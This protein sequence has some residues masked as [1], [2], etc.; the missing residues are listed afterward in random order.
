MGSNILLNVIQWSSRTV[1]RDRYVCRWAVVLAA[2]CLIGMFAF[3]QLFTTFVPWD[4]E[5]Y[6]LQ[7]YRDFLSGRIL[8]D[9]V[10]TI[11]G[12]WTFFSAALLAGFNAANITHDALRWI[13][14]PV[15]IMI[16]AL[17][18]GVV[19][20]WTDRFMVSVAMFLLVGFHLKGLAKGVGHPQLWIILAVAVLLWSG[21]DWVT[22]ASYGWHAFWTGAIIGTIILFKVNIG[23]FVFIS[24]ALAVSLHLEGRRR[25]LA[26]GL[27]ITAAAGLGIALLLANSTRSEKYFAA[28]YLASLGITLG[29]AM[30]QP[31]KHQPSLVNLRR[32]AAGLGI[33]LCFGVVLTL[34]YGTTPRALFRGLVTGPAMFVR[35]YHNPF[36]E[37]S[38]TSSILI[39]VIGLA[40]A[41]GVFGWWRLFNVRPAWLGLLK[42][43]V[44]A[45][46]LCAFHYDHRIALTGSL[47]FL[48]LLIIDVAPLPA[49]AHSNRLLLALLSAL[50]S[51][52]LFPMAGEQVDWAALMPMT[53]AAVLLA[54]G[55]NGMVLKGLPVSLRRTAGFVTTA[56]GIV[57]VFYM[58]VFVE[59]K[60]RMSLEEWRWTKS[61]NLPGAYWLRLPARDAA[62]LTLV[63][64]ELNHNCRVLLTLPGMYSFS[65]WSGV[66][67]IEEKRINTWPFL[68]PDEIQKDTLPKLRRQRQGCVLVNQEVYSFFKSLA[69]S[70]G[71]DELLSEIQQTMTPIFAAQDFTLYRSSKDPEALQP[72]H[73]DRSELQYRH[74]KAQSRSPLIE[75]R[76]RLSEVSTRDKKL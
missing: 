12:P 8:Y 45:G 14:L 46:L 30:K 16:A 9:Q 19:W 33:C 15:W 51:L 50:F 7:A 67:P 48:W 20:R 26:C 36:V 71:H 53:A 65:I 32:L 64:G 44:G 73:L 76:N 29:V 52:Q 5:G 66:A 42:V 2:V 54:D 28:V 34:T 23:I 24:V 38:S 4:D 75:V 47:L 72:A 39:S 31:T 25:T 27:L 18:A 61:V 49:R 3:A 17:L 68:W 6:F 74:S 21:L 10:F 55:M 37:A 70:R 43:T 59:I 56:L 60:T 13:E 63:V 22:Q 11:Y 58:F 62:L 69:V 1:L 57:L 35:S 41:A 40:T